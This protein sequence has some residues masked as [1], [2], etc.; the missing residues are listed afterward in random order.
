[1]LVVGGVYTEVNFNNYKRKEP[2]IK[3]TKKI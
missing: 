2:N 3:L 1:M